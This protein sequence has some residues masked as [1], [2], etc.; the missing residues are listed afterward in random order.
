MKGERGPEPQG[1]HQKV[2]GPSGVRAAD[3]RQVLP[4]AHAAPQRRHRGRGRPGLC[5][6]RR[7]APDRAPGVRAAP[8]ARARRAARGAAAAAA[9]GAPQAHQDPGQAC[10]AA[11][12][13]GNQQKESLASTH[14]L[15]QF[16]SIV[17]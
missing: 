14:N 10:G 15:F 11:P 4:A 12:A 5:H 17:L 6:G 7:A 3:Q 16:S 9:A 8:H 2:A 1:D 13:Q